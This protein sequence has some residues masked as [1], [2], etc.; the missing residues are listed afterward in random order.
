MEEEVV[1]A[2]L[3][4]QEGDRLFKSL[5]KTKHLSLNTHPSKVGP[6]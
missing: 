5:L 4:V 2:Y 6:S 3:E 1:G